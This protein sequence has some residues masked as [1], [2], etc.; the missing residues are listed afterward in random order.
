MQDA[1]AGLA[2]IAREFLRLGF[3][4]F[5]GPPVHFAMMEERFV[6]EKKWLSRER[7][8][9][10]LGAVNLLPGPSST[11]LTIYLGEVRAGLAGLVVAGICFILPSAMMVVA[12]AWAYE[13]FGK[14]P[15]VAGLLFGIKPVVVAL[16]LPALWNLAKV[17]LKN[18]GL[19]ML[20]VGV[21]LLA[22]LGLNVITL[23]ICA[24]VFWMLVS[25]ARHESKLDAI[26]APGFGVFAAGGAAGLLPVFLY[27]LKIGA[28]VFG[29][30][31]VLLA[32][33]RADL[34]SR[35]H[36]L[37]DAQLLDAI[38]V[39]QATPGPYFTVSTFIGYLLGGC[40]GAALATLGMFLPAFVFVGVTAKFLPR[41]R[42]SPIAGAFL[43]GVNAAAVAL[44]AEVSF[45]F[46]RA[47]LVNVPAVVLGVVSLVLV[48]RFRVNSAWLVLGGALAGILLQVFR[49]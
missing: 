22:V 7:F 20:A 18:A 16:I 42:K 28:V 33:L 47:A 4:A 44:M 17:A 19:V 14:L 26:A 12:L 24:G 23:L 3:V 45:Q 37:T 48:S 9:D 46:A 41:I 36:W 43:D 13:N 38:A 1:R 21:I 6:R 27:F 32:V 49:S 29:S 39:S 5:G 25:G 10:L 15:Q 34:V 31:Y 40:K 2:D 35:L 11:E 8:L 30:G